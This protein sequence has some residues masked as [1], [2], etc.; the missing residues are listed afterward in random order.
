MLSNRPPYSTY[1]PN[2]SSG[3]GTNY[4]DNS[5]SPLPNPS[6][7][8]VPYTGPSITWPSNPLITTGVVNEK[9]STVYVRGTFDLFH[10]GHVNFLRQCAKLVG[11]D[12]DVVVSLDS[13]KVVEQY[14]GVAP[15][16]TYED[17]KLILESCIYVDK[18]IKNSGNLGAHAGIL[19]IC[20]NYVAAESSWATKDYYRY[21]GCTQK[22]LNEHDILLVYFPCERAPESVKNKQLI[23]GNDTNIKA[24]RVKA[25]PVSG[26]IYDDPNPSML[27]DDMRKTL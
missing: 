4:W 6:V 21:L 24:R 23:L 16:H 19:E 25:P 1:F 2:S 3:D 8:S 15:V 11:E 20:P 26:R 5:T 27:Y 7:V 10:A 17:R 12:G 22:W 13:D 9:P 18:V 14:E